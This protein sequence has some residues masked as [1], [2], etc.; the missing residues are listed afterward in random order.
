VFCS[1]CRTLSDNERQHDCLVFVAWLNRTEDLDRLSR[2]MMMFYSEQPVDWLMTSFRLSM[3]Q[4][5]PLLR[6]PTLFQHLG[7]KSSF[8]VSRDNKLKDRFDTRHCR[9]SQHQACLVD[10][11]SLSV[12]RVNATC[13]GTKISFVSLVLSRKFNKFSENISLCCHVC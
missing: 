6:K 2:Y 8:D 3:G 10:W 13:N 11:G 12:A 9:H 7:V 1:L 4:R 5:A